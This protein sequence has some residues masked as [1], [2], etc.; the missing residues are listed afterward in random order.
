MAT[1]KGL[2]CNLGTEHR[3]HTR[4]N[5]TM[6]RYGQSKPRPSAGSGPYL[7]WHG[8]LLY[9]HPQQPVTV[10]KQVPLGQVMGAREDDTDVPIRYLQQQHEFR[11]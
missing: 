4:Q 3:G 8:A 7:F 10:P 2:D 9:S 11:K 6:I 1:L 5:N